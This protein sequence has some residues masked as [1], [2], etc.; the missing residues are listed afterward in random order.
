MCTGTARQGS[1][2]IW[3]C[4]YWTLVG[5]PDMKKKASVSYLQPPPSHKED[6][7]QLEAPFPFSFKVGEEAWKP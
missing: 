1:N 7:S 4:A 6:Q 3:V 5:D 2:T